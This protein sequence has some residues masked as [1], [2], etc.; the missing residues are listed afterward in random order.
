MLSIVDLV[1]AGTMTRE[2]AAY[3]M[4]A[5]G[6]GASF[7][8]GAQPSGAGKTTVMGALL[9]FVPAE[10]HLAPADGVDAISR[11]LRKPEPRTCFVCHEIGDGPY[12]AYLWDETL[13][14]YFELP[15]AGHMIA[16]NLHADTYEEAREQVCG[17]NG[18][19]S[20]HFSHM[21]LIYFL[22]V[23]SEGSGRTR[24]IN[25]LWE[26]N[27]ETAH[28]MIYDGSSAEMTTESSL[29]SPAALDSAG[30]TLDLI[31]DQDARTIEE[32]RAA[33][34]KHRIS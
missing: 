17:R 26:S 13:R 2:M 32:V 27:G 12:Y 25:A 19:K 29:V 16:T 22:T 23:D 24:R 7:M 5:I 4:A 34:L 28:N 15:E 3:S 20:T 30:R 8:V 1:E 14:R 9:N 18:V 6:N 10:V 33:V 11:G 31:M 21:H